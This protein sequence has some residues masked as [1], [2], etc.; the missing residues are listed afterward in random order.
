[1]ICALIIGRAGSRGYPNKNVANVLGKK[2]CEYPILA[3]KNSK[4]VDKIYISTD[5]PEIKEIG[6]KHNANIIERPKNLATNEALGEDVFRHGY[7]HIK[8]YFWCWRSQ[9]LPFIRCS[10]RQSP[11]SNDQHSAWLRA[12]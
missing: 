7:L 5:S 8:S 4:H 10:L 12:G 1:M 3:A 2:L 6:L 9:R 11:C